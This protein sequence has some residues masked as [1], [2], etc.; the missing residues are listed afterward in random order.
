VSTRRLQIATLCLMNAERKRHRLSKLRRSAD[1]SLAAARHA[2]D[3]VAHGYF[4]HDEPNGRSVVDRILSSGYL[5]RFGRWRIGE[6]LGWGWG[7]GGTPAAIVAAWMRSP[8][9]RRNILSRR[10]HDVGVALRQG[11][12]RQK[13]AGSITY[14]ID[15]GGFQ[16]LR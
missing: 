8:P 12:P 9:H 4:A 2:R 14:V 15:F 7:G 16:T 5:Q 11:S 3:M 10:F 1:L 6:N 13:R